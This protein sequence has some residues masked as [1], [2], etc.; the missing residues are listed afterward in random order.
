MNASMDSCPI[1]FLLLPLF[2]ADDMF[3]P[4]NL[5]YFADLLSFIM[6]SHNLNFI[7]LSDGHGWNT[8]LLSQLFR[9]RRRHNLP[10]NVGKCIEMPFVILAVVRSH[11]GT[12]LHFDRWHLCDGHKGEES[13]NLTP[14]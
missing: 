9:K 3:L 10:A 8:V 1:S 4:V 14:H 5:G 11:K 2:S 7:I 13:P 6:S 12:E